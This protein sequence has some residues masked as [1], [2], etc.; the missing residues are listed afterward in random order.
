MILQQ[1]DL[2]VGERAI[3]YA[4]Y[5]HKSKLVVECSKD[6][7][8]AKTSDDIINNPHKF[9]NVIENGLIGISTSHVISASWERL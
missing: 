8:T 3:C 2:S 5:P 7:D 9:L 1:L 6:F 4:G